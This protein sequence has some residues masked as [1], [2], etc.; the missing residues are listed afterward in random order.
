MGLISWYIGRLESEIM[1]QLDN[2][3]QEIGINFAYFQSYNVLIHT[4]TFI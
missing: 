2:I 3:F 4:F 1:Y